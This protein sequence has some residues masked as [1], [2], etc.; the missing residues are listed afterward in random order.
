MDFKYVMMKNHSI[1]VRVSM[2]MDET[3][4]KASSFVHFGNFSSFNSERYVF[5]K[6]T[7]TTTSA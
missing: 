7:V 2:L 3:N 1:V 6:E 5:L 4:Q